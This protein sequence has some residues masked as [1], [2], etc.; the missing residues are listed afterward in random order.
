MSVVARL[1]LDRVAIVIASA[2][3]PPRA[4]L[5]FRRSRYHEAG[6]ALACTRYGAAVFA[7][8]VRL[9]LPRLRGVPGPDTSF[10]P[11]ASTFAR[12][13]VRRRT[14]VFAVALACGLFATRPREATP[15]CW[16]G[17][18]RRVRPWRKHCGRRVSPHDERRHPRR[19][20]GVQPQAP[21][22][23]VQAI[24]LCGSARARG[25]PA[26]PEP[27]WAGKRCPSRKFFPGA[28]GPQWLVSAQAPW[29]RAGT[30]V[31]L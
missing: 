25:F 15:V 2:S 16:G 26:R 24:V 9:Q 19:A 29:R 13:P 22:G 8:G 23:R 27:G 3:G 11:A 12:S 10:A 17:C 5:P 18:V 7:N 28:A 4:E 21:A 20:G 14:A 30:L 6:A 31:A 1:S